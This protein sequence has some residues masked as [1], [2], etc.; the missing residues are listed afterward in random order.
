V[1]D[2]H[3]FVQQNN[4]SLTLVSSS[5]AFLF[6]CVFSVPTARSRAIKHDGGPPRCHR[7]SGGLPME[8]L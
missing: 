6:S 7:E 1:L 4:V 3:H 8:D 5:V 2:T